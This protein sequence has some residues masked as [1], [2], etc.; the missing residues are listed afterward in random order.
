VT[1]RVVIGEDEPILRAGLA[2]V[3]V[4]AEFEVVGAAGDAVDL[5]RKA[6]AHR[7]DIVI[8]DIQMPPD[9]TDDGLRA[10]GDIR[11]ALPQTAVLVLTQYLEER[12]PLR[13]IGD[14]AE[15]V[16]YLLK[17]RIGDVISFIEAVKRVAA[18]GTVLDPAVVHRMVAR[19]RDAGPLDELTPRERDVLG[20]MAEG[21]SNQGIADVLVV[22]PGAVERHV[23]N[24]FGKLELQQVPAD[25]RRVLAV[26]RYLDLSLGRRESAGAAHS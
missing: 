22:T 1:L 20:L 14:H 24:I 21:R 18:G 3:L 8:T 5:V 15:G 9:R 13:L 11:D 10:A 4:E 26:L 12:Y 16:G 25:H 2:Q 19:P 7:P 17:D 23:T 6:L